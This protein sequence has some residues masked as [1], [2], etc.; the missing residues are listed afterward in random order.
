MKTFLLVLLLLAVLLVVA[1]AI[2]YAIGARL[3]VTHS[4]SVTGIVPASPA[5]TLAIISNVGDGAAWRSEVKSVKVLPPED[6]KDHWIEDLGRGMKMDF[7]ATGTQPLSADGHAVRTI[8]LKDPN[9]GGTWT[10]D[11]SHGPSPNQTTLKITE[12][13]FIHSP[14]YRFAMAHFFGPTRN[15]KI[16]IKDIQKKAA[17]S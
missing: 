13:G 14:I 11:V 17:Q 8:F 5:R 15:L 4:V 2:V 3:P 1:V 12:D 16:Y 6:G 10:Y 9:Y 7:V